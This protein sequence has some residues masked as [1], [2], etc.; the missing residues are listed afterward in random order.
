MT[1]PAI[2]ENTVRFRV[3]YNGERIL[4]HAVW[5]EKYNQVVLLNHWVSEEDDME[6]M[7]KAKDL[8]LENLK[9]GRIVSFD[10]PGMEEVTVT[11]NPTNKDDVHL[12]W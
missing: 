2:P 1:D 5:E 3:T 4:P 8:F 12:V 11:V 9:A 7:M 10:T 6:L